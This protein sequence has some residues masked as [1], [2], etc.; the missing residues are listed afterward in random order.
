MFNASAATITQNIVSLLDRAVIHNEQII[1][2]TVNGNA[3]LMSE[4]DYRGLMETAYISSIPGLKDDILAASAEPL[5]EAIPDSEV[6][7]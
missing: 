3:V 7:A 2:S 6:W 1:I 4:E 5:S